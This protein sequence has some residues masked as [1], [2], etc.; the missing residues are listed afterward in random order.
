MHIELFLEYSDAYPVKISFKLQPFVYNRYES[1]IISI[2]IHS[3]SY[4]DTLQPLYNTVCYNMI[5]NITRFKD[6]SQKCIDYMEK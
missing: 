5:L 3:T 6:G 4:V 1:C 2:H